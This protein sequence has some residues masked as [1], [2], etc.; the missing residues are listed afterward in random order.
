MTLYK[1]AKQFHDS[2][3]KK[4]WDVLDVESSIESER[5]SSVCK[6]ICVNCE[7]RGYEKQYW[8]CVECP[9]ALLWVHLRQWEETGDKLIIVTLLQGAIDKVFSNKY[10]E[11]YRQNDT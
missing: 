3:P 6:A 7:K 10:L 1:L 5:L 8:N 9:M 11:H 4:I 2:N